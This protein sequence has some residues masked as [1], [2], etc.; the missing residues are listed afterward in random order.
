MYRVWQGVNGLRS[1]SALVRRKAAKL[2]GGALALKQKGFQQE[3]Q[4]K[5]PPELGQDNSNH[6]ST[7]ATP[8]QSPPQSSSPPQAR[9]AV[10][11]L[12]TWPVLQALLCEAG[13]GDKD[14][15]VRAAAVLAAAP[16]LAHALHAF[17]PAA[18]SLTPSSPPA[19]ASPP[20]TAAAAPPPLSPSPPPPPPTLPQMPAPASSCSSIALT[21]VTQRNQMVAPL[22]ALLAALSDAAP[23]V[24]DAAVRALG[25]LPAAMLHKPDAGPLHPSGKHICISALLPVHL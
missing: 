24:R 8:A 25:C 3:Q 22:S 15:G 6:T 10:P 20:Q 18:H 9:M 21:S 23:C 2:I 12:P 19:P 13:A 16:V 1:P 14:A 11:S 7:S 4:H 5:Q 17:T